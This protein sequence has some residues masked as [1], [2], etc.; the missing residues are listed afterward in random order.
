MAACEKCWA[1][2]FTRSLVNGRSQTENYRDLLNE[3]EGAPCSP[4]EQAGIQPE[5]PRA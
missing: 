2:A 4:R 5:E 3:R 1:D